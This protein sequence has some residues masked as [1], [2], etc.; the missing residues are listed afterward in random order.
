M[1]ALLCTGQVCESRRFK[2]NWRL[3]WLNKLYNNNERHRFTPGDDE[4][5]TGKMNGVNGTDGIVTQHD[6]DQL[7]EELREHIT[8]EVNKCKMDIIEGR[9]TRQDG[10]YQR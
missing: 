2:A 5:N 9:E 10:Y 8:K 7:R 3:Q 4:R 6:L 1:N